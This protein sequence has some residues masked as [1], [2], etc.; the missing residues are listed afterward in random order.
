MKYFTTAWWEDGCEVEVIERYQEYLASIRSQLPKSLNDFENNHTL[1]DAE[2][3]SVLNDFDR[4]TVEMTLNGYNQKL[5]YPVRYILKFLGVSQ[6]HQQLPK[7]EY[8]ESELGDL[9]YTE[10]ELLGS[11]VEM[12]MLFVSHA[13]FR[14]EFSDFSF[15]HLDL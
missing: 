10:L 2:V 7:Q 6:F 3:E 13:E 15:E 4:Q 8:I 1:H 11:T 5:E 14:I 12:R 9:G